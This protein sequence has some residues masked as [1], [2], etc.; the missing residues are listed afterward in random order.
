MGLR[1]VHERPEASDIGGIQGRLRHLYFF[2]DRPRVG[3]GPLGFE[4]AQAFVR[5]G[6]E[7]EVF[8][9]TD[10]VA[11]LRDPDVAKEV[12]KVIGAELPMHFD[13]TLEATRNADF[14]GLSWSG[15]SSSGKKSF[16]RVLVAAGRPPDLQVLNLV[17]TEIDVDEHGVPEIDET[18]LQC[19][20]APIFIAGDANGKR[21]V[22]H[23][24]S[25]EGFVAGRNAAAYPDVRPSKRTVPLSIMFTDPPLAVVGAPASEG[26]VTGTASYTAQARAKVDACN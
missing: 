12:K 4:L 22:L 5:L 11:A 23:E 26:I 25:S 17:A 19:G 9:Q 18:T 1:T 15:A 6:V 14:A 16:E 10:R 13:A 20:G 21:R 7:T 8:E 24:A 2:C 3:A